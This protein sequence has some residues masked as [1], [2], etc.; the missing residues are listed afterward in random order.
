MRTYPIPNIF[1]VGTVL[2]ANLNSIALQQQFM[3]GYSI[4]IA[5]T[6][7]PTGVFKLQSSCDPLSP[8]G[9]NTGVYT[10]TN[11]TDVADS[12]FTVVAAGNVQW[13]VMW[14]NYNFVRVVYTDASGG[15][16]TAVITAANFTTKG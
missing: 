3:M 15:A 11:W 9:I 10:P 14:V 8:A 12:S 1:P 16:S 13:N 4:Q 7:T 2:N 5:F 6:G